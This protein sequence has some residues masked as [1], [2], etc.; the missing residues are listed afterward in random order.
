MKK[1]P[2]A[3]F[4]KCVKCNVCISTC[5][6]KA[7]SAVINSCCAKCL[8]Y[9]IFYEVTCLHEYLEFNMDI[10]DSCG[11]CI[12]NCPQEALFWTDPETAR[13]KRIERQ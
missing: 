8:K 4:T 5:P 9:C 7:I 11:K 6:V 2:F 12:E 3:D 10:C 1:I 13:L